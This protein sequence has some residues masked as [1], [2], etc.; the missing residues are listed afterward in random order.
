MICKTCGRQITKRLSQEPEW[1]FRHRPYC[2]RTCESGLAVNEYGLSPNTKYRRVQVNGKMKQ[3]HRYIVERAIGRPLLKGEIVHHKN[4]NK[5]D[6][7]LENLEITNA[8]DHAEH[9]LRKHPDTN[10]CAVCRAQFIPTKYKRGGRQRTCGPACLKI[11]KSRIAK[12]QHLGRHARRVLS[13]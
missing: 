2:S 6:N 7:H 5:L 12:Q 10:I 13:S 8:K 11:L 4:G 3:A 9:H 1:A